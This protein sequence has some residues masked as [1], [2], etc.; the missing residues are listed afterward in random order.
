MAVEN[1]WS[2][3]H[4]QQFSSYPESLRG[5]VRY[6]VTRE[7]INYTLGD[8]LLE[9]RQIL[10]LGGGEG[11]DAIWIAKTND[12][13]NV[14]LVE[15]D[16]ESVAH[17]NIN[18]AGFLRNIHHGDLQTALT[19]YGPESFNLVFS[20][21]V[22]Q[23][24]PEPKREIQN[25]AQLVKPGGYLSLLIDG[26]FGK[27]DRLK[28][29]SRELHKLEATGKF[30]NRLGLETNAYLPQEVDRLIATSGFETI[31]W[32]GVRL[33]SDDDDR[34]LSEIPMFHL[35]RIMRWEIS[36]SRNPRVKPA[37]Q[38]LHFIVRKNT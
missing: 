16:A 6:E 13:H 14:V 33:H 18:G 25:I 38:M 15:P 2:A 34:L 3:E 17:A 19:I 1:R 20:H 26:K 24:L 8:F 10:D 23:Y 32:F 30:I 9:P 27:M 29:D 21:G 5:Y 36:D 35:N 28:E 11:G 22:I 37:G 4:S 31:E 12:H 7:N